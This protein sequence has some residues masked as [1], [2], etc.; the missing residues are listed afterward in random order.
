M[1]N[2]LRRTSGRSSSALFA[3]FG[4]TQKCESDK[5][6]SGSLVILQR[7]TRLLAIRGRILRH[8]VISEEFTLILGSSAI[9]TAIREGEIV[10]DPYDDSRV[11]SNSYDFSLYHEVGWYTGA[12]LD[13]ARENDFELH[14][15]PR[16]GMVLLPGSFYLGCTKEVMGSTTY[17]PIIKGKSSIARLG[18][19]IHA[20]ADLIDVGSI[21]RWTLHLVP[22][23][24]VRIFPGM[25]IGQVT[26]WTVMGD[27]SLYDGKYQGSMRPTP[28]RSWLDTSWGSSAPVA[29]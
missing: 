26:F 18:L 22:T 27:I 29:E 15:L 2:S 6:R 28:S 13:S 8:P 7:I 1:A 14:S 19:F 20:T 10:I 21:N 5:S 11:T 3:H 16:E 23:I 25:L 9:R 24:P 17:V 4:Y 12:E